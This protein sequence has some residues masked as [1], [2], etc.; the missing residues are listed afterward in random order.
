M[1]FSSS[2]EISTI[3]M[4]AHED[5]LDEPIMNQLKSVFQ[6]SITI[7]DT[8]LNSNDLLLTKSSS[9]GEIFKYKLKIDQ[10]NLLTNKMTNYVRRN[11]VV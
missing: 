8:S 11:C 2:K 5:C 1:L 6:T 10:R 7:L 4:I 9:Q 3:I